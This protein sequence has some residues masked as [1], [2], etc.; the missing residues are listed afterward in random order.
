MT[1]LPETRNQTAFPAGGTKVYVAA[2]LPGASKPAE[3]LAK[4][5]ADIDDGLTAR[6][7]IDGVNDILNDPFKYLGCVAEDGSDCPPL[8]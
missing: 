8:M 4:W 6:H 7:G 3:P 5:H 2:P 1:L